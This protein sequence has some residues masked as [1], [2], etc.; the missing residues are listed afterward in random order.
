MIHTK[1]IFRYFTLLILL[2]IANISKATIACNLTIDGTWKDTTD[3]SENSV[4][5]FSEYWPTCTGQP[6]F[7]ISV[8]RSVVIGDS[9]CR[10]LGMSKNDVIYPESEVAVYYKNKRMYF[11]EDDEWKILYDFNLNV[12]DTLDYQLSEINGYYHNPLDPTYQYQI[13]VYKVDT[14]FANNGQPLKRLFTRLTSEF[15]FEEGEN[16]SVEDVGSIFTL[17]GLQGT[18]ITEGCHQSLRCFTNGD[19]IYKLKEQCGPSSTQQLSSNILNLSPN[20]GTDNINVNLPE[21]VSY[22]IS[23]QISNL[24]GQI[25]QQGITDIATF[26]I[27]IGAYSPATYLLRCSD[28]NG[29]QWYGKWVK[30]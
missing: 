9:V 12:G 3:M 24:S 23:Y 14:V 11:Y 1:T 4:W 18:V 17:F 25:L 6:V 2:C 29:Q 20:P 21:G 16:I 8:V 26:D 13:V 15:G 27:E 28:K 7:T 19:Y 30:M 10:V 22:P 5:Y